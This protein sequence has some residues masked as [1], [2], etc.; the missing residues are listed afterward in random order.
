MKFLKGMKRG[1]AALLI[2]LAVTPFAMGEETMESFSVRLTV[3]F[4]NV[5]HRKDLK[6]AWG[7]S[8]LVEAQRQTILF[9]TGS[10][11]NILLHNMKI[12]GLNPKV[13]QAVFLSHDHGDHTGGLRTF[14]MKNPEVT[15]YPLV[16]FS[17][18]LQQSV[19]SYG[20]KM[21]VVED[22]IR[23]FD[24]VYSTGETGSGIKEQGLILAT[25]EGLVILTGCAH[26]GIVRMVRETRA[27]FDKDILLVM[28]GFHLGGSSS[29]EIRKVAHELRELGVRKVAPSHCTGPEAT[30]LLRELW[31]EDFV[32]SGVGTVV[33]LGKPVEIT[34]L[35]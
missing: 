4:D 21:V 7:F 35:P 6:T 28:G 22:S 32:E 31:G 11:G 27:R 34:R 13:I 25:S 10:D 14:L 5:P 15:V 8:C 23:L 17:K 30:D 19:R 18:S 26:P 9:D 12:L 20:A 1:V 3:L 2:F 24:G 16:T 29:S 33:T